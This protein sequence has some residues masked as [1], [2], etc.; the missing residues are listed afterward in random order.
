MLWRSPGFT[1]TA[2]VMLAIGIGA[3]VAA[4]GFLN[5]IVLRPLPVRDPDTLLRFERRSPGAVSRRT[6]PIRRWRSSATHSTT[7]SAVL[8]SHSTPLTLTGADK[9]HHRAL[10]DGELLRGAGHSAAA[11][12]VARP[13]P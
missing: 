3:N 9:P 6:C 11:G 2:V 10:R 8:A 12:P 1:L 4:F 5:L 13:V 7:L